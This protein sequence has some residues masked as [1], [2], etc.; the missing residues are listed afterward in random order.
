MAILLNSTELLQSLERTPSRHN[1]ML[2]GKHGIG[3][4]EILTSFFTGK[5]MKVVTLF[6]GQMS[7]PGDLIGLPNKDEKTGQTTFMPPY[8]FPV[9]GKP[10]VLFLDELNRARPEV[11]QTVMD[12]VLNKKL[13]GRPLPEG[14][15]IISAVNDGEEYQLTD[16]DPALVSRFNIYNFRPT[17]QEW[18]LWAEKNGLD[19][20]VIGFIS[21]HPNYLDSDGL[22]QMDRGLEKT[23][24][25]RAWTRVSELISSSPVL[26]EFDQKMIAGIIGASVTSQFFKS[27]KASDIPSAKDI[28]LNY[29]KVSEKVESLKVD[30]IAIVNDDILRYLET[31]KIGERDEAKVIANF[32]KYVAF[33]KKD[34]KEGM[35]HIVSCVKS[36]SY[37]KACTFILTK[38]PL[39]YNQFVTFLKQLK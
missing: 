39:V 7:D 23:P 29:D 35:A 16:L 1:I 8:W 33:L 22:N 9:D 3:K 5:G 10:I 20:R 28:L 36:G 24:D 31:H 27:F 14:S 26:T 11:L 32:T 2:V 19:K 38:M 15:R 25:R 12:L 4:S 37:S 18:L 21:D 34:R 17:P 13:A 6:L 30:G